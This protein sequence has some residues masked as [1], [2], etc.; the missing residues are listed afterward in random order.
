MRARNTP[1]A[2]DVRRLPARGV[3]A[4]ELSPTPLQTSTGTEKTK[5][6]GLTGDVCRH[7][8]RFACGEVSAVRGAVRWKGCEV[9]PTQATG[10]DE[11]RPV[12]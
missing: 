4:P 9:L 8:W 12:P 6:E 3:L 7:H 1:G 2:A 11:T 5:E 10:R